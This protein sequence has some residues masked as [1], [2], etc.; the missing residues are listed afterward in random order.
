[1]SLSERVVKLQ[2]LHCRH[3]R[4]GKSV[5]GW[6]I[7][8]STSKYRVGIR[9]TRVSQSIAGVFLDSLLKIFDARLQPCC[10]CLIRVIPAFQIKLI[11]LRIGR[12]RLP[13]I[14]L[15]FARQSYAQ[16][17]RYSSCDLL[18]DGSDV[19]EL[20]LIL[21]TP[22]LPVLTC[23]DE[24]GTYGEVVPSL[25]DPASDHRPYAK[26]TRHLLRLDVTLLVT[27]C[28]GTRDYLQIW[29]T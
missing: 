5:A 10:R 20:P 16:T 9:Q 18:L 1:M 2:R 21:L 24:F 23:I 12:G 4:L 3:L 13:Q 6:K 7:L 14:H 29:Q 8:P 11:R 22:K 26:L 19:S 15:L 25:D 28:R 27:E 17:S